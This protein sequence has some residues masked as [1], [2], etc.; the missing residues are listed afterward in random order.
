MIQTIFITLPR[1]V[2]ANP[3]LLNVMPCCSFNM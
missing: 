2:F 1:S 3:E